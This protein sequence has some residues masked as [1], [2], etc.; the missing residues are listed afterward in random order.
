MP[1]DFDLAVSTTHGRI[2]NHLLHPS[3]PDA[4]ENLCHTALLHPSGNWEWC[5]HLR[6][7]PES[8]PSVEAGSM[9]NQFKKPV[10]DENLESKVSW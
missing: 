6:D 9:R 2:C 1:D 5:N 3:D 4:K 7:N 10:G 8:K